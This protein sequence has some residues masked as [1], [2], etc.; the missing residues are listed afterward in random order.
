MKPWNN[1]KLVETLLNAAQAIHNK[2]NGKNA[3]PVT[4]AMYWGESPIMQQLRSL[5]EKVAITDANIL[6]T[7]ENG[8]TNP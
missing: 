5:V 7:G 3:S 4:S 6:I 1:Q 2:N 8:T